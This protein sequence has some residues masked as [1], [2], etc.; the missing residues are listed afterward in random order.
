LFILL[1]EP[2]TK[3][4]KT[5]AYEITFLF[6]ELKGG[7]GAVLGSTHTP[8]QGGVEE[9]DRSLVAGKLPRRGVTKIIDENHPC[10]RPGL[11]WL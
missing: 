8:T 2:Y 5:V 9:I 10:T 6:G 4:E 1:R 11:T 7:G 3:I